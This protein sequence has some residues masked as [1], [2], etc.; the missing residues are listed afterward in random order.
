MKSTRN[1]CQHIRDLPLQVPYGMEGD[2]KWDVEA[3]GKACRFEA[4]TPQERDA[5]DAAKKAPQPAAAETS[6]ASGGV[7][8]AIGEPEDLI[9]KL[10]KLTKTLVSRQCCRWIS[11]QRLDPVS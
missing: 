2:F 1:H 7:T 4:T 5:R 10:K 6:G 3:K 8:P 11:T 9:S